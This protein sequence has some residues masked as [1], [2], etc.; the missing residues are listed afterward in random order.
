[1]ATFRTNPER[2]EDLLNQCKLGHIKLPDFQRSWVWDEDR[3]RSL[4][5]SVSLTFPIGALMTLSNDGDVQFKERRIH[6]VPES[7]DK[8]PTRRFLLDGQQRM[9]SLYQACMRKKAIETITARRKKVDRWLYISINNALD[10]G[11][12]REDAIIG[13]PENR[14]RKARHGHDNFLDLSSPEKEYSQGMFPT[15]CVFDWD[16]WQDGYNDYWRGNEKKHLQFRKFKNLILQDGF[17]AY[18]V[19]VIELLGNTSREAVCLVF[20]KV[21]TGGRPL[22]AFELVT[23]IY[24]SE[25]FELRK[26]WLGEN[27][28]SGRYPRLAAFGRAANQDYGLLEKINSTDFLQAVSLKYSKSKRDSAIAK[29]VTGRDLPPISATRQALLNL[30]LQAYQEY[31][32]EIEESFKGAVMFLRSQRIYRVIDVP[33]PSQ[34]VPLA[35]I[36]SELGSLWENAEVREK[37]AQWYWNG[38]FGELYGSAAETRFARDSVE[39]PAWLGNDQSPTTILESIF[40]ADRLLTMRSRLSAAYK[41]VNS[42]LMKKGARDFLTGQEFDQT[43]FFDEAVDIHHIF[44]RDW[45][46]RNGIPKDVYDSIINKTPLTAR[47]NRVLGGDA[48]AEYLKRIENGTERSHPVRSELIDEC[49]LSHLIDPLLL[50]ANDFSGF[51]N[52]RRD[53]LLDLIGEATGREPYSGS[54]A[55]EPETDVPDEI[56]DELFGPLAAA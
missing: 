51:F 19:P 3:L 34:I 18:D 55:D 29:G 36:I 2:L 25:G 31:A 21:N 44:P 9:T 45:C 14:M 16:T 4:I 56:E 20:E 46:R 32:D 8:E 15:H 37:V 10:P 48:P 47:T 24:A 35:V 40:N 54:E 43:V 12:N 7:A 42:L 11:Y 27:A 22:D 5:A 1:M 26:D 50:R 30:P 53:A 23:A 13:V 52:A 41:G 49:L 6:G 38:V 39:V 17:K 33:Y 28:E